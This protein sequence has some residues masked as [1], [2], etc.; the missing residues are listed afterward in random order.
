MLVCV[1]NGTLGYSEGSIV[2]VKHRGDPPFELEDGEAQRLIDMG[3]VVEATAGHPTPVATPPGDDPDPASG[4]NLGD[5]ETAAE[6]QETA[7]LDPDQ[8]Q[9]MTLAELKK[10]AETLYLQHYAEI[11]SMCPELIHNLDQNRKD[12]ETSKKEQAT[13]KG[14][15]ICPNCGAE[16]A[17]LNV[18]CT[19][20]GANMDEIEKMI[21]PQAASAPVFCKNCGQQIADGARFCMSCGKPV[22]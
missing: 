7:R 10:L 5:G 11:K 14:M 2:T 20:C 8:L 12:Y 19:A 22:D 21:L 13:L 4:K 17:K 16:Q 6:G 15:R 18:R 1:K 9:S 3:A